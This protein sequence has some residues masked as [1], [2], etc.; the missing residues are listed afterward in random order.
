MKAYRL[1]PGVMLVAAWFQALL[2]RR[3]YK[4]W[5][6]TTSQRLQAGGWQQQNPRRV[7]HVKLSLNRTSRPA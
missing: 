3:R 7:G 2:A 5:C 4:A 1:H 6:K